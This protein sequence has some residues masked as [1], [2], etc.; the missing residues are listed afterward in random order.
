M[1]ARTASQ[2]PDV[3][4]MSAP[5]AS[6]SDEALLKRLDASELHDIHCGLDWC[7]RELRALGPR[8]CARRRQIVALRKSRAVR[9]ARRLEDCARPRGTF[10][11]CLTITPRGGRFVRITPTGARERTC[12]SRVAGSCPS[13]H[14]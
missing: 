6:P 3:V 5:E 11:G 1:P 10:L 13:T 2:N 8:P 7:E 9:L 4:C 12:W 14:W